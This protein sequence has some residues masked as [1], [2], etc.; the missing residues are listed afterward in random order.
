MNIEFSYLYRD[1]SNYKSWGRVVFAEGASDQISIDL[2]DAQ[3]RAS[4]MYDTFSAHQLSLP[5]LFTNL[6]GYPGP[7][8]HCLHEFDS[9]VLTDEAPTD[10]LAR[11]FSQFLE[12]VR[13]TANDGWEG[14]DPYS[15]SRSD[16]MFRFLF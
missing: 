3:L 1:A 8:D 13:T 5:E 10:L 6:Q 9:I 16:R 7:D 11:T 12:Q 2:A 14:F 15:P 4:F